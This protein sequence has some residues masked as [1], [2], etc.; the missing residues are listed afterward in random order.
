MYYNGKSS[1]SLL[2]PVIITVIIAAFVVLSSCSSLSPA[3]IV[4]ET[5]MD[6]QTS[7]AIIA[8]S[9]NQF[10]QIKRVAYNTYLVYDKDTKAMYLMSE[11][12]TSRSY[13]VYSFCPYYDSN[14]NIMY[15]ESRHNFS[16]G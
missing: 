7:E 14:S 10:V 15:Y 3:I 13:K 5:T 4:D 12:T 2:L 1:T 9:V 8:N 11:N 16:G 6:E